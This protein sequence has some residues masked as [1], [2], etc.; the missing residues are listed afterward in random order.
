MERQLATTMVVTG[1]KEN[2]RQ[3]HRGP[4]VGAAWLEQHGVPP[5]R[6]GRGRRG[7]LVDEPVA[8]AAAALH[9]RG[10]D[11]GPVVTDGFH[12]DRSLAIA[13]N[14]GPAGVAGADHQLPD[15]GVGDRALLRQGDGGGGPRAD[16]RVLAPPPAGLA[17]EVTHSGVV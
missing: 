14:V 15:Q 2:G 10:T 5:G 12:E 16:H 7:R 4:G 6:H 1:S 9:Q 11:Q 8:D 3:V 17:C 13:S